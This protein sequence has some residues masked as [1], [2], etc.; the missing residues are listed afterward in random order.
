[1][2]EVSG[3]GLA[4]FDY[5]GDGL[6]DI[7]CVQ[8]G[9]VRPEGGR[10]CEPNRLYRNLG[11]GKFKETTEQAG[12]GDRGYGHGC[13]TGDYDGD[14]DVDLYVANVGPNVLYRNNGDG[15]FTDVTSEAHVA[16]EQW[17]TACTF[18]DYDNDG[19]L[20]LFVANN[21]NWSPEIEVECRSQQSERDYCSPK[22][23]SA[24][25]VDQLFRNDGNGLFTTVTKAAGIEHATGIALGVVAADFDLDGDVDIY[26]AND[27]VPNV[28][29]VNDGGGHFENDALVLGCAVNMNGTAE[30]S[31]GVQAVDV[32]NDG[33]W[34]LFMTHVHDETNTFYL[35]EGGEFADQTP[36]TGL[37]TPSR[38]TTGF[39]LA[40][41][42]FDHDGWLDLFVANGR[43]EI[44]RPLRD[45]KHPYNEPN[46]LFRG[47]GPGRFEELSESLTAKPLQGTSRAAA[48]GDLDNDGDTDI[49]YIDRHDSAKL[50]I[51]QAPKAGGWVGFRLLNSSGS[52]ALGAV[53]CVRSDAGSQYRL[54]HTTYSYAAANDP[55]VIFGLGA[56][57]GVDEVLV[58]WPGG[59]R[60]GFGVQ[61]A[62]AYHVLRQG[63]G[64]PAG[65]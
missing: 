27:S 11:G 45:D 8:S 58:Q 56:S 59:M 63:T 38:R 30:A 9:D 7:Y 31:M 62:G 34:D 54:C 14:G 52:D 18:T 28:M 5:D 23:Y 48:F 29:W 3:G 44:W 55:R 37:S 40:F 6:L 12:V 42:D 32:E 2:P 60:E 33:D 20:D 61:G 46:Q 64:T 10:E 57:D 25:S 43:V 13:A 4:V 65:E 22:N 21:L 39:G 41:A 51:N 15:T 50:L 17:S 36:A 16:G 47:L 49:V 1:M 19:D 24:P 26:V 35:N 53:V